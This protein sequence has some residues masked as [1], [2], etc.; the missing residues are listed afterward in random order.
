MCCYSF[1]TP[2]V[3]NQITVDQCVLKQKR[4]SRCTTFKNCF[5]N[6]NIYQIQISTQE[7][8]SDSHFP[9]HI[10]MLFANYA[11]TFFRYDK[12]CHIFENQPY[13]SQF[14]LLQNVPIN[15]IYFIVGTLQKLMIH[16]QVMLTIR[17]LQQYRNNHLQR[18]DCSMFT[19][20]DQTP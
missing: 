19:K 16:G 14:I 8:Q 13:C 17:V 18:P 6:R 11:G 7:T 5:L 10:N 12:E 20:P 2:T 4:D 15:D 3:I 1:Y 9:K